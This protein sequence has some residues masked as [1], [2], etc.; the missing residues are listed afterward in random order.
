MEKQAYENSKKN[1]EKENY[2]GN[3]EVRTTRH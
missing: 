2:K 3:G 1:T